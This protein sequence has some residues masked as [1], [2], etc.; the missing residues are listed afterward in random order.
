LDFQPVPPH[1]IRLKPHA[2]LTALAATR[3]G[4]RLGCSV[5]TAALDRLAAFQPKEPLL[6]TD[7]GFEGRDRGI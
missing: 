7:E 5:E 3:R 6:L 4:H 2:V 1:A